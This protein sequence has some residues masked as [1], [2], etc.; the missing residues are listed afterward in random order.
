MRST[1]VKY[2][3]ISHPKFNISNMQ[4]IRFLGYDLI[5]KLFNGYLVRISLIKLQKAY[6]R[7]KMG[8]ALCTIPE[9]L[10]NISVVKLNYIQ[11]PRNSMVENKQTVENT[12]TKLVQSILDVSDI[13]LVEE[14]CQM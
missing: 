6:F 3:A 12:S 9:Q 4:M 13:V 14:S 2:N 10:D 7:F 1:K 11:V 8:Q 5:Q